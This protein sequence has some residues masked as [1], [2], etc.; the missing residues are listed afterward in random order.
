MAEMFSVRARVSE[1]ARLRLRGGATRAVAVLLPAL[2]AIGLACNSGN[3]LEDGGSGISQGTPAATAQPTPTATATSQPTATPA[4]VATAT[5][6][7]PTASPAPAATPT[8]AP[9]ATAHTQIPSP[10]P[11]SVPTATATPA[12]TATPVQPEPLVPIRL[13]RAFAWSS[14]DEPT[15]LEEAPDGSGRVYVSE[16]DGRI[17]E[18]TG[19]PTALKGAERV[20]LDIRSRVTGTGQEEGL[21]GFAL[22]PGFGENGRIFI[23]YSAANPQRSIIS[24]FSSLPDGLID[25]GSERIVMEVAQPR[26]NH[27]GG[28]LAFGPDGYLYISLGDGGGGGDQ[29]NNAQNTNNV[30]GSILRIDVDAP[31]VPYAVP[32]D[33]PFVQGGGAPEIWAYGLR[34]PWRFSFDTETGD[35]WA[36]DV[37]QNRVE[38]IDLIVRGGNYGWRIKEGPDCFDASAICGQSGLIEPVAYYRHQFGC[39]VTGGYVF[40]SERMPSLLGAYI[41]ADFCS[42]I[43]FAFRY[44]DG[45]AQELTF[46]IDTTHQFPAFGQTQDGEVYVLSHSPGIFRFIDR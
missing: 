7:P 2:M 12:P 6:L 11:T 5:S 36:A 32:P 41:Y 34:N 26:Q 1:R 10:T 21:L 38:E 28:M 39:S 22:H 15:H 40:R 13:Q 35:L 43:I 8:P 42:G 23:Y 18:L 27:N 37:G 19:D 29:D 25:P 44:V 31:G 24:E 20:V 16:Q 9:T 4:P 14:P 46:L 17:L 45:E 33:N 30:L 3:E